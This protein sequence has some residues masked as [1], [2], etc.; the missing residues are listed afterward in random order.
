MS[1]ICKITLLVD[2]F[3]QRMNEMNAWGNIPLCP[4]VLIFG[5]IEY[6]HET[7]GL[8]FCL[9][10][11]FAD[12]FVSAS[13]T[14]FMYG[15]TRIIQ[16]YLSMYFFQYS[17]ATFDLLSCI[18]SIHMNVKYEGGIPCMLRGNDQKIEIPCILTCLAL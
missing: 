18:G 15:Y 12:T 3:T 13:L 6:S 1:K 4:R 7:K 14:V 10:S 9:G 2:I 11:L 5:Q 17:S 16:L 8:S